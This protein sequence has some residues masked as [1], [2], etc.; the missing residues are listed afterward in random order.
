LAESRLPS[1]MAAISL[2]VW[3]TMMTL[4]WTCLRILIGA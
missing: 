4:R 1:R 3:V 2:K